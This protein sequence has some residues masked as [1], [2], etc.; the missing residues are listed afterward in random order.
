MEGLDT[1]LIATLAVSLVAWGF[2]SARMAALNVS[3]P[4]FF[5]VLGLVLA[6]EPRDANTPTPTSPH[7]HGMW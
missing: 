5:V 2:V 6:N 3:A 1:R 4:M 7:P